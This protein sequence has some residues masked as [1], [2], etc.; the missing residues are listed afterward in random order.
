MVLKQGTQLQNG[1][2]QIVSMLT[3][4][5]TVINYKATC[6][7][8][9][10]GSLGNVETVVN[11]IL[12]EFFLRGY[13]HRGE[14][15]Q[16]VNNDKMVAKYVDGSKIS[17]KEMAK[18][19]ASLN[20]ADGTA[21]VTDLFEENNTIYYVTPI[22]SE[23][24]INQRDHSDD[25]S[26]PTMPHN[27]LPRALSTPPEP[28][29][30]GYGYE[31]GD[32]NKKKKKIAIIASIITL[33]I[34]AGI[35]TYVLMPRGDESVA[36][37]QESIESTAEVNNDDVIGNEAR[38]RVA[39]DVAE[40]NKGLPSELNDHISMVSAIYDKKQNVLTITYEVTNSSD[41][42]AQK[43]NIRIGMLNGL[44][45]NDNTGKHFREALITVKECFRM[46]GTT[47]DQFVLTPEDYSKIKI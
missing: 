13:C 32:G 6:K 34:L 35:A 17:F 36:N 1:K 31:Y 9:I 8:T 42:K 21:Q 26:V 41:L 19:L 16:V 23:M 5:D 29:E 25:D 27:V 20:K 30:I 39:E 38:D 24:L 47:I 37:A 45:S 28:A 43:D 22:S 7:M 11:V 10:N 4:D 14:N 44:K 2:Y 33:L 15:D 12:K 3:Q 46:N 18:N 40:I